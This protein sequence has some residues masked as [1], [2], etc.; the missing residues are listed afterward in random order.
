MFQQLHDK[1]LIHLTHVVTARVNIHRMG[2]H[3]ENT[4]RK[5]GT[6]TGIMKEW[7]ICNKIEI[8]VVNKR[9]RRSNRFFFL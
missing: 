4:F 6:S 1:D 2:V 9:A 5:I 3:L 7:I 8:I